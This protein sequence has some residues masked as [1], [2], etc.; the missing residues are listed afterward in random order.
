MAGHDIIV[1]GAS[2][3]GVEALQTLVGGLSLDLPATIFVVMHL[4]PDRR[5][6]LPAILSRA[7]ALPAVH[8]V[9]GE[10]MQ[11]G[12]VSIAPPDHHL[13]LEHGYARITYGPKEN[14]FRPAIDALFRSAAYAYGPRVIGVVLSGQLDDGTAG[15]WAVKD[16][17]GLAIVLDPQDTLYSSM[18]LSA[19]QHVSVDY[20]LPL[21]KI[22]PLLEHLVGQTAAAQEAYSVPQRLE[23]ETRIALEENPLEAGLLQLGEISPYTC[24]I[25]H[26]LMVQLQDGG[27]SRFRCHTG[28]AFSANSLLHELS[29]EIKRM[30]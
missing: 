27:I 15:L 2:A 26:G 14:R 7:G 18:P 22:A 30:L 25:C 3:G 29:E 1:V 24:P 5:S 10:A 16:R 12:C 9:D 17:G 19:M 20:C 21:A 11:Q 13:V 8:A 23:I 4:S 6:V 28:H